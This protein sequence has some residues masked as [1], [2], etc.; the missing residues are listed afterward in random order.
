MTLPLFEYRCWKSDASNDAEL[1]HRTD[2]P[3]TVLRQLGPDEADEEV[4]P[5]Y[6]VRFADGFEGDVFEDELIPPP[7]LELEGA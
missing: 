1:W 3:V 6:H 7:M 5:M 2:Q 4:G